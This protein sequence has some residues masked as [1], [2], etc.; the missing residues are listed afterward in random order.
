MED[1][2][3]N[4]KDIILDDENLRYCEIYKITNVITNKI[5]IGQAVS[6][7]LNHKRYR[8]YGMEK[9]FNCHISEAFSVKKNQCHYL[10]NSIRK[11]G[12]NNFKLELICNCKIENSDNI[13][14]QQIIENN[15]L[16]PDGYNLNTGGVSS[17]HTNESRLRVSNGVIKYFENKKHQR[18]SDINVDE[19]DDNIEKYIR[20]LNRNK[21][22]YGWYVYIKGKKS[23]FRRFLY[24][25]G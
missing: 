10:N 22:Q 3:T 24:F 16:Y 9:R 12:S 8:P 11:H 23:R 19:I 13:E 20:P 5:Y 18:F 2:R 7:I 4:L 14:K 25:I 21:I 15:S 1:I 17:R 6:H